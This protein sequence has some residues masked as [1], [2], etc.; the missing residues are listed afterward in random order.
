MN[1]LLTTD[2]F[3]PHT[4]GGVEVA[5]SHLASEL[6]RLGH[7]VAV[8]T[9]NTQHV[10]ARETVNDISV[11]R[12][13]T[14]ELTRLG[15]QGAVSFSLLPTLL[16]ACKRERPDIVHANSIFF[17]TTIA[18]AL[19]KR[20]VKTPLI[21][22]V[23]GGS[24]SHLEG[25]LRL[26]VNMYENSLGRW[27]LNQSDGVIA[28][29]GEVMHYVESL[30]TPHPNVTV[31]PNA[32]D[33]REFQPGSRQGKS[34]GPVRVAFVGRLLQNKGPQYFVEAAAYVVHTC[35]SVRFCVVGEGPLLAQLMARVRQLGLEDHFTFLGLVPNVAA[36][37]RS[38]DILVRPSLTEGMPLTA[39]EAMACGLPVI[40]SDVGGTSEILHHG[41]TGFLVKPKNIVELSS[42]ITKLV[43]DHQLRI[44]MGRRA[45]AFAE[46]YGDWGAIARQ[47]TKIYEQVL[48]S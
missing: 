36:F 9:L 10:A 41:E 21:T 42:C 37:L 27:V 8:V 19:A 26:F 38:C 6:A 35:P 29:S 34:S 18:A 39:L 47:I 33:I 45:R 1:V 17:F 3:P 44:T 2:Y 28:V 24:T 22:T 40:A 4:G 48:Q 32:V 31:I 16:E 20:I 23:H 43:I 14:V 30:G 25:G 5:V 13:R 15:F 12:A 7:K 46:R 11:Y